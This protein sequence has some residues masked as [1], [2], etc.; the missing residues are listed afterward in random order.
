M[1]KLGMHADNLRV[2]SGSFKSAVELGAKYKLEHLEL[3]LIHI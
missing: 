1:I 3:S 2:L